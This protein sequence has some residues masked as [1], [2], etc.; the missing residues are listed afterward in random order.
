MSDQQ[1]Y[2][3][4]AQPT[5]QM[6]GAET[7]FKQANS[8]TKPH[9]VVVTDVVSNIPDKPAPKSKEEIIA[10]KIIEARLPVIIITEKCATSYGSMSKY[11]FDTFRG[12]PVIFENNK[13]ESKFNS[14]PWCDRNQSKSSVIGHFTSSAQGQ[15]I[16]NTSA[17][18]A[19]IV[20]GTPTQS[21]RDTFPRAEFFSNAENQTQDR[22]NFALINKMKHKTCKPE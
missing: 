20:I 16:A 9:L 15:E 10:Q 14:A 4:L 17:V 12:T 11:M 5:V 2:Q 22:V 6:G 19:V 8:S 1:Q 7:D 18:D 13:A 21:M 3:G